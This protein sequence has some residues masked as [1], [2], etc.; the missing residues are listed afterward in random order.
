MT[1]PFYRIDA[2]GWENTGPGEIFN[3]V[4]V[5][6]FSVVSSFGNALGVLVSEGAAKSLNNGEGL[7][8]FLIQWKIRRA[9]MISLVNLIHNLLHENDF[10]EDELLE[11]AAEEMENLGF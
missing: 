3:L 11:M 2:V 10:L 6:I 7:D 5:F 1:P 8:N 4:D 9:A